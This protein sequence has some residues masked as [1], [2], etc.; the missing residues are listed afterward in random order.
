M[1]QAYGPLI[2]GASGQIGRALYRL[3]QDGHLI[4]DGDPLWQIRPGQQLEGSGNIVVW[5]I[6][7]EPAPVLDITGVI[8][9]AGVTSG[10]MVGQNTQLAQQA[11]AVARGTCVLLASSQA[12]Y[13]AKAE[14][15][16]HETSPTHPQSDY[17]LAKLAM[18]Q[19]VAGHPKV[20][21]LR[22]GNVIGSDQLLRAVVKGRVELHQFGQDQSPRRMMIGPLTLGRALKALLRI[23]TLPQTLNLAQPSMVAMD[24]ILK[25]IG[26][27]W[28]WIPA[29]DGAL[30]FLELDLTTALGLI[31][32]ENA[33]AEQLVSEAYLGGWQ[34]TV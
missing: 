6:L 17:G 18:E 30:P 8:G 2:L 32:L 5:D 25:A 3:W 15:V 27:P 10:M 12:V 9:L 7:Q 11:V 21:C 26:V 31:P 13:G 14:G 34:A 1:A 33:T 29:P 28:E 23:K 22:L 4:F 20:T 24:D 19:A 16:V